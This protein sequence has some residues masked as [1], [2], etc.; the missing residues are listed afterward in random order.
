MS[1][2]PTLVAASLMGMVPSF[3]KRTSFKFSALAARQLDDLKR[4]CRLD[5]DT[6]TLKLALDNLAFLVEWVA[7]GGE[8]FFRE[9]NSRRVWRYTPYAP[10]T[11]YPHFPADWSEPDEDGGNSEK[12]RRTFAFSAEE[13]QRIAAI[14]QKS[15]FRSDSEVV[16]ASIAVLHE[17]L[18]AEGAGDEIIMKDT[19]G[20]ERAYSPLA[21]VSS[22]PSLIVVRTLAD[23]PVGTSDAPQHRQ[24]RLTGTDAWQ[25]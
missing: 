1:N 21:P 25:S 19:R 16:R 4:R 3:M 14:K 12:E 24:E 6:E 20:F 8:M 2:T 22:R 7:S 5:S 18:C 17:L 15:R 13:M 9:I 23:T 11:G 10:P